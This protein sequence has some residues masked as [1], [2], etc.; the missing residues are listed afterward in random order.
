MEV[1][2][3]MGQPKPWKQPLRRS[4]MPESGGHSDLQG[5]GL[6]MAY[7]AYP[8]LKACLMI[9]KDRVKVD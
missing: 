3:K 7:S 2:S 8:F 5:V 6:M 1:A 9:G 4:K